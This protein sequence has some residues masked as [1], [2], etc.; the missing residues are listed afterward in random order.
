M[1]QTK[2]WDYYGENGCNSNGRQIILLQGTDRV[3]NIISPAK[4]FNKNN[5]FSVDQLFLHQVIFRH[6]KYLFVFINQYK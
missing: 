1:E 5:Y 2:I 6:I 3:S 4:L